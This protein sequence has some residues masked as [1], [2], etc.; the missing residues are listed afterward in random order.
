MNWFCMLLT[1]GSNQRPGLSEKFS[2]ILFGRNGSLVLS[3]FR[4]L[5]FTT[6]SG[7]ILALTIFYFNIKVDHRDLAIQSDVGGWLLF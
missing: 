2:R 6:V 5:L 1:I 4:F 7:L 3:A